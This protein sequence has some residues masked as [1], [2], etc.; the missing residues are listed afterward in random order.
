MLSG[1]KAYDVFYLT[2]LPKKPAELG[3][4][5]YT[6]TP[7]GQNHLNPMVKEMCKKAEFDATFTNHSLR[8][9]GATKMFQAKVPKSWCNNVQDTDPWRYYTAER[10]S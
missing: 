9:Y 4:S 5:W 10:T 8:T 2:P 6:N 7:V 3:K 1:T